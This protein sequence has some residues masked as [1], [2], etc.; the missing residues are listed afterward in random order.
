MNFVMTRCGALVDREMTGCHRGNGSGCPC[1]ET[2]KCD[3][4]LSGAG[5][6]TARRPGLMNKSH[7]ATRAC[8]QIDTEMVD[9]ELGLLA[10][11]D[12][13]IRGFDLQPR[14]ITKRPRTLEVCR[15]QAIHEAGS[16]H[17]AGAESRARL[18]SVFAASKQIEPL[19]VVL[20][21]DVGFKCGTTA[22]WWRASGPNRT[23]RP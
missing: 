11:P 6:N 21:T 22:H 8:G 23:T 5:R 13:P 20:L 17:R 7:D 12:N 1:A 19:R 16:M 15:D 10:G 3:R 18:G 4:S 2:A 14:P 9:D